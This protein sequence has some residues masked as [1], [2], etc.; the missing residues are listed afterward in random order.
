MYRSIEHLT[1]CLTTYLIDLKTKPT[2]SY[3]N[4]NIVSRF[5]HVSFSCR[6]NIVKMDLVLQ[7]WIKKFLLG[8]IR[9]RKWNSTIALLVFLNFDSIIEISNFQVYQKSP[10]IIFSSIF[11]IARLRKRNSKKLKW[12]CRKNISLSFDAIFNSIS[13]KPWD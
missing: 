5:S 10:K 3:H 7:F 12:K 2:L 6:K 9:K 11:Q 1:S 4:H 8:L 13:W